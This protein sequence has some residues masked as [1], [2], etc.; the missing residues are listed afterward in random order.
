[1]TQ[2]LNRIATLAFSGPFMDALTRHVYS[3][4]TTDNRLPA[5]A[6]R[7]LGGNPLGLL[8]ELRPPRMASTMVGAF[9]LA[10]STTEAAG[11]TVDSSALDSGQTVAILGP[12]GR[13]TFNIDSLATSTLRSA[14]VFQLSGGVLTGADFQVE[15][16]ITVG[17]SAITSR[18]AGPDA[19]R[20]VWCRI[21][22]RGAESGILAIQSSA[23]VI[24][25]RESAEIQL[26]FIDPA[27][28]SRLTTITD[29]LDR[30][31]TIGSFNASNDRRY[32][33]LECSRVAT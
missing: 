15:S 33:A 9:E 23:D 27:T 28:Y 16:G 10:L 5:G 18:Q 17:F 13:V 30:V 2:P 3:A 31:W 21:V 29:D 22:E 32:L 7:L 14:I 11:V 19:T 8:R 1:M 26:R 20:D 4:Y 6:W 24:V 25:V 12:N